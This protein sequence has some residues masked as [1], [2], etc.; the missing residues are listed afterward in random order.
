MN[1][2]IP[3]EWLGPYE[4][5][6]LAP[7]PLN[8]VGGPDDKD[9]GDVIREIEAVVNTFASKGWEFLGINHI[10]TIPRK[11]LGDLLEPDFSHPVQCPFVV[12]RRP[13]NQGT[14]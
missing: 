1:A 3:S 10:V 9:Y 6:F 13:S 11:G 5:K 4:Y 12:L 14:R 7:T 2:S 8:V